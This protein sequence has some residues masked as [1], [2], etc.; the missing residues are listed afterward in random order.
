[1]AVSKA[2]QKAV[3]KFEKENYEHVNLRMPV[4]TKDKINDVKN[5]DMSINGYINEAI[6]ERLERDGK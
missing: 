5:P 6:K 2:A 3:Y 1:M 4:G